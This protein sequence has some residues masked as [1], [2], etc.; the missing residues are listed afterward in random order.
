[1]AA[2]RVLRALGLAECKVR[3]IFYTDIIQCKALLNEV[4]ALT[5][6]MPCMAPRVPGH[7]MD[8][9]PAALGKLGQPIEERIRARLL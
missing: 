4:R 6:E 1:M 2:C 9:T 7:S 5:G 8:F 3:S